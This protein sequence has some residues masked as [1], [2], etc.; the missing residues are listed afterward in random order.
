MYY[1]PVALFLNRSTNLERKEMTQLVK[2]STTSPVMDKVTRFFK[3]GLIILGLMASASVLTEVTTTK[4]EQLKELKGADI[5]FVTVA[6]RER[7][8]SCLAQNIYHEAGYEPFEGKVAVAQVTLN[9]AASG[10]FPSDICAVVYQ[11]SVIYSKVICQFSWYCEQPSRM[12]PINNAAF[13]ESMAVAKK[14]LLE[15]FKLDG[16]KN[17][18]YYHADYVNPQWGKEKIAQIGRHIF[19][20]QRPARRS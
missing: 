6:E 12:R 2:E 20:S 15:G 16:L 3:S 9:R 4:L 14:V 19:Y 18:I 17:A 8:L 5:T 7:Q 11:K 13:A 1:Y 10:D